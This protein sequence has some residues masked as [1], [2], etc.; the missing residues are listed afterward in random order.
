MGAMG[1]PGRDTQIDEIGSTIVVN[2]KSR[3]PTDDPLLDVLNFV[4]GGSSAA[5]KDLADL[6]MLSQSL[7]QL[8][9][10]RLKQKYGSDHP[11]V[12]QIEARLEQNLNVMRAVQVQQELA[13]IQPPQVLE[14]DALI[15]GRVM[16]SDRLGWP[17]LD[18]YLEN[19]AGQTLSRLGSTTTEES[20]YFA[21]VI[22]PETLGTVSQP[23]FQ[24]VYLSIRTPTGQVIY[25]HPD[26]VALAKGSQVDLTEGIELELE[27]I[28]NPL[29]DAGPPAEEE[30]DITPEPEVP[31]PIHLSL[32]IALWVVLGLVAGMVATAIFLGLWQGW[33]IV[34]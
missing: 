25:R 27:D 11:Q 30:P 14:T 33:P 18:I 34:G 20:G 31:S 3:T 4:G 32:P 17:D 21:L 19:A 15:Q 8:E 16:D 23:K 22:P 5:L 13:S 9:A 6:Q 24:K 12:Q 10:Q 7:F 29:G 28:V 2:E 26:P 1:S